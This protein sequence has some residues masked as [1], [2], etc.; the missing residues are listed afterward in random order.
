MQKVMMEKFYQLLWR[1]R[2]PTL[3]AEEEIK[4]RG[5]GGGGDEG[6]EVS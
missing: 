4:V 5:E 1:P 3:L 2:P 6:A